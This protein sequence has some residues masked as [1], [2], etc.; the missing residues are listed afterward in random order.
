M[1]RLLEQQS[2]RCCVTFVGLVLLCL[3]CLYARYRYFDTRFIQ[4]P[5]KL[6]VVDYEARM[7]LTLS[8]AD[9]L[10]RELLAQAYG[11]VYTNYI[12]NH[13]VPL[14]LPYPGEFTLPNLRAASKM[15][16][17]I[18]NPVLRYELWRH[19]PPHVVM[20]GSS[21]FFM[22]FCRAEFFDRYPD[23][24]LLDFTTGDNTPDTAKY[25]LD[26]LSAYDCAIP[27]GTVFLYGMNE[28]ELAKGYHGGVYPHLLE[29]IDGTS[30]QDWLAQ[31]RRLLRFGAGDVRQQG[32]AQ[33]QAIR[34]A[35]AER[36]GGPTEAPPA[37]IV[38][39]PPDAAQDPESLKDFLAGREPTSAKS[40]APATTRPPPDPKRA[41]AD[42]SATP[43]DLPPFDEKRVESFRQIVQLVKARHSRV[44]LIKVP[45]S[46]IA[47]DQHRPVC[48][49]FDANIGPL[50]RAMQVDFLDLSKHADIGINDTH[51][52][53]PGNQFNPE[54]L[55]YDGSALFTRKLL[56]RIGHD[57]LDPL[58]ER[59][60]SAR[61]GD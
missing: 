56:D 35:L 14:A 19:S 20:L 22:N 7:T 23:L 49:A 59:H 41:L 53:Y 48:A 17:L 51:Y 38:A 36:R 57:W 47:H 13:D 12:L 21:M 52:I 11:P 54:H 32:W 28:F 15:Y 42:A 45:T 26:Q 30:Q 34:S 25:L 43:T 8:R 6:Y 55:N 58:R 37:Y 1:Q 4:D 24:K 10:G 33:V 31:Q 16:M 46:S 50:V 40:A 27:P 60:A 18:E 3:V 44:L 61:V 9:A 39:V 5:S 29:A 2:R